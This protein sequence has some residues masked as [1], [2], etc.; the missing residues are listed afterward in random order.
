[1]LKMDEFV[2]IYELAKNVRSNSQKISEL[3]K[4]NDLTNEIREQ[5]NK[6]C[7]TVRICTEEINY[8]CCIVL[9]DIRQ[10][11]GIEKAQHE[12]SLVG[13]DIQNTKTDN[14]NIDEIQHTKKNTNDDNDEH[15]NITDNKKV[16]Q[17]RNKKIYKHKSNF[18][19]NNNKNKRKNNINEVERILN[20][21][22]PKNVNGSVMYLVKWKGYSFEECTWEPRSSF[23][24]SECIKNYQK[25]NKMGIFSKSIISRK[26]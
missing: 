9:K 6:R 26:V 10:D 8:C 4:N 1:M 23:I 3:Y 2:K 24:T 16:K 18:H 19:N 22:I 20:H 13:T 7:S 21:K 15:Q 14:N 12:L 5:M 17:N 11:V 25:K